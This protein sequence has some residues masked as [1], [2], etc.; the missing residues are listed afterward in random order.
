VSSSVVTVAKA[1]CGCASVLFHLATCRLV[2]GEN[3]KRVSDRV[4]CDAEDGCV[5][6]HVGDNV[7]PMTPKAARHFGDQMHCCAQEAE[8]Q[9]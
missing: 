4:F 3:A 7:S 8:K 9:A 2:H 5:W 6:I 1:P